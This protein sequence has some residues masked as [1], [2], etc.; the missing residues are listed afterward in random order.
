MRSERLSWGKNCFYPNLT[1]LIIQSSGKTNQQRNYRSHTRVVHMSTL[2]LISVHG[3]WGHTHH[4]GGW[5]EPRNPVPYTG[6]WRGTLTLKK[7]KSPVYYCYSINT[8]MLNV[9]SSCSTVQQV[10]NRAERENKP[11]GERELTLRIKTDQM[12]L[13]E[14]FL[15]VFFVR[16]PYQTFTDPV[17]EGKFC[18]LCN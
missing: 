2:L 10:R 12:S 14:H 6:P 4:T 8:F 9:P 1:S 16:I 3:G 15:F 13:F 18:V 11:I 17:S 7:K 5:G